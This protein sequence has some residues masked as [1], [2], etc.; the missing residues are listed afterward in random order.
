MANAIRYTLTHC[1]FT[2]IVSLVNEYPLSWVH[3]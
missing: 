3:K 2:E 1:R